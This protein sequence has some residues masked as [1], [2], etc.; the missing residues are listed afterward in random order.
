[1]LFHG[2]SG[3]YMVLAVSLARPGL[4]TRRKLIFLVIQK[5][6]QRKSLDPEQL[7]LPTV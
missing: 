3:D 5:I 7:G 1:M 2:P 6:G 4:S